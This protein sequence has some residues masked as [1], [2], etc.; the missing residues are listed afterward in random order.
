MLWSVRL[1]MRIPRGM[2]SV[3]VLLACSALLAGPFVVG[4]LRAIGAGGTGLWGGESAW[5]AGVSWASVWRTVGVSVLIAVLATVLAYPASWFLARA[6]GGWWA[7]VCAPMLLPNYLAYAGWGL[8]RDPYLWSLAFGAD[9]F[10]LPG[11]LAGLPEWARLLPGKVTAVVGLALWVWPV[12]AVILATGIGGVGRDRLD[13]GASLGA[14][15]WRRRRL[16]AGLVRGHVVLSVCVVGVLMAGS[17]VPL[18]VAQVRTYAV[19][20]WAMLAL[21]S[22]TG[23]VWRSGLPVLMVSG[24]LGG[25]A[26]WVLVGGAEGDPSA[27]TV[28]DGE[29]RGKGV[30]LGA[31][32]WAVAAG[33]ALWCVSVVVPVALFGLSLRSARSLVVFWDENVGAL[34]GSVGTAAVVGAVAVVVHLAVWRVASLGVRAGGGTRLLLMVVCGLSAAS[35]VT[36]GVLIGLS[37][38]E[39]G[40]AS[41]VPERVLVVGAHVVRFVFVA[42]VAGLYAAGLEEGRLRE[43]REGLGGGGVRGWASACVR[44]HAG[45]CA[46]VFLVMSVL[47]LHEIESSVVLLPAGGAQLPQRLLEYLHFNRSERLGASVVNLFVLSLPV[48]WGGLLLLMRGGLIRARARGGFVRHGSGRVP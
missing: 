21:T 5:F 14:G 43:V 32:G 20:L 36:P 11:L 23:G 33:L 39:I 35:F 37:A 24:V 16:E 44:R 45:I 2:V 1:A 42:V 40:R 47:S 48:A 27:R 22:D 3:L 31:G 26:A 8:L 15:F 46:G 19:D 28:R 13:A 18:H 10:S 29:G 41:G 4:A 6:G 7:F 30:R 34:A 12:S 25:L 38:L 9:G 17:A